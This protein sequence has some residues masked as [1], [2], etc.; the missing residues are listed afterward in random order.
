MTGFEPPFSLPAGVSDVIVATRLAGGAEVIGS[1]TI[2]SSNWVSGTTGWIIYGSGNVEFNSG[3]FSGSI[4][5]AA[6]DIPDTTTANSFHVDINGRM[7]L[8]ATTF[9][10]A[11]FSVDADGTALAS[12]LTLS[13]SSAV[14]G[15]LITGTIDANTI[16]VTNINA[17][18]VNTGTLNGA[19]VGT[20][21]DA[22]FLSTGTMPIAR[23]GAGNITGTYIDSNTIETSHL[24]AN[25]ITADELSAL[26]IGVGKYIRST[27]YTPGS[28]GWA[29]DATGS[30]EFNNITAYGTLQTAASG[31]RIEIGTSLTNDMDFYNASTQYGWI[32]SNGVGL[33]IAGGPNTTSYSYLELTRSTSFD[34]NLQAYGTGADPGDIIIETRHGAINLVAGNVSGTP[35]DI[36][37]DAINDI[38][39]DSALGSVTMFTR[40]TSDV[41]IWAGAATYSAATNGI[42]IDESANKIWVKSTN[43]DLSASAITL[44]A[45]NLVL[46]GATTLLLKDNG[47]TYIS[48]TSANTILS[49]ATVDV[50]SAAGIDYSG[51]THASAG[52][53][54]TVGFTWSSPNLFGHVDDANTITIGTASDRRLKD[55]IKDVTDG[56]ARVLRY[57]PVS[58]L[59]LEMDGT[60]TKDKRRHRSFIADEVQPVSP[61][62]VT[63]KA[64]DE[65]FQSLHLAG[66]IPDL[67]SAVHTLNARLDEL[68]KAA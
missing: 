2:K 64:D 22:S 21:L 40:S 45:T 13:G 4:S 46:D 63:G 25:L 6:L 20:G 41:E 39:L 23:V 59:A 18:N 36:F 61:T 57:R 14:S 60:R 66:M 17:T 48:M 35:A 44:D 19:L 38:I 27:T 33:T 52:T 11:V 7:W 9:A 55:D 15:S 8:G 67:V 34:I 49:S 47:T 42:Q 31:D 54:N 43:I 30:A 12:N 51:V 50:D 24:A 56:L 37:L 1:G 3:T 32:S 68:E 62:L 65:G 16:N 26:S 58:F 10:G 5:A 53:A 29:I 28:A